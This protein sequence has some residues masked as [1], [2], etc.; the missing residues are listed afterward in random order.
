MS[1]LSVEIYSPSN[2][3]Y[4]GQV[5]MVTVPGIM[6]SMG[7]LP[8]HVGL[9][10]PL[11]SGIVK[12]SSSESLNNSSDKTFKISGGYA[13]IIDDKVIILSDNIIDK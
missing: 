9:V 10:T 5:Y 2:K 4:D 1:K 3:V 7:F 8:G 11:K 13:Q 12:L 6:G